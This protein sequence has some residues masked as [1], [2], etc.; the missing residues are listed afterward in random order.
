MARAGGKSPD[1]AGGGGRTAHFTK[2]TAD[3]NRNNAK[4][5]G[6]AAQRRAGNRGGGGDYYHRYVSE[7]AS[8]RGRDEVRLRTER[9]SGFEHAGGA[10]PGPGTA[11]DT[12]KDRDAA[13]TGRAD[14][15]LGR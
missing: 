9:R 11:M 3:K 12:V 6:G 4:D 8:A 7:R 1:S 5:R 15:S 2:R 14:D 13:A 10:V